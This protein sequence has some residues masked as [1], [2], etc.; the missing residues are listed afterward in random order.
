LLGAPLLL[1]GAACSRR[2]PQAAVPAPNFDEAVYV[3][4]V[5]DSALAPLVRT[6]M[7]RWQRTHPEWFF[8]IESGNIAVVDRLVTDRR[9]D[10][11]AVAQIPG[12]ASLWV[13]DLAIDGIAVVVNAANPVESLSLVEVR[14]I[15]AGYR[16]DWSAV[17]AAGSGPVQVVVRE[18]GEGT[19]LIFDRQVMGGIECKNGAV[20]MP[21]P[22]T[23][24]NYVALHP[25]AIAYVA[26]G[27]FDRERQPKVRALAL[28]GHALTSAS[29]ADGTY[30][31]SRNLHWVAPAK[32]TGPLRDFLQWTAG[33]EGRRIAESLGYAMAR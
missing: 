7:Q 29:L 22:E 12:D 20:V 17:V 11:A 13:S 26:S 3:R 21:T 23:V 30:P 32:P 6:L 28:D 15:F 24:L 4:I 33:E 25:E 14:E 18:D 5:A 2:E 19:R 31:L 1:L 27:R 9:V 8:S 16:H 10:L